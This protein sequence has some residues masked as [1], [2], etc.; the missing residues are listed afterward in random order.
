MCSI[1]LDSFLEFIPSEIKVRALKTR[2]L[3]SSKKLHP[4]VYTYIK[5]NE[6]YFFSPDAKRQRMHLLL[7]SVFAA[8]A[9]AAAMCATAILLSRKTA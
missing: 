3:I 6:L 5:R 1:L 4:D 7:Y 2:P 8:V 9:A